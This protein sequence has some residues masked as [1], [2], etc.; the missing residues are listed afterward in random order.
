MPDWSYQTLFRPLL[1]RLPS[2]AARNVT[3]KAMRRVSRL[4]G[5]T[6]L[7][8][9]LGHMEPSPLLE[10]R[11]ANVPVPTPVGLS[12]SVDPDRIAH[13]A[14][15]QFGFGFME[16]GP[17]TLFPVGNGE[18]IRN[19]AKRQ[20]LTYPNEYENEGLV[21]LK[22]RLG[23]PGH[24]LPRFFRASPM[25]DS[26]GEE[27]VDQLRTLLLALRTEKTAGFHIDA[28][29][30]DCGDVANLRALERVG[31]MIRRLRA[32][33]GFRHPVSLRVP[34]D[35]PPN[36]LYLLLSQADL[37]VWSGY[38]VGEALRTPDG[39]EI[40]K[41]GK[42]YAQPLVR[43]LKAHALAHQSIVAGAGVHEPQDAL[44][45]I[46]EGA[47]H[48]LLGSGLVYAGPGLPKRIN[49]ALIYEKIK[50][51]PAPATP[52]FWRHWGWMRLLGIGMIVGGILAWAI[53]ASSVVLP[54]DE[55]F[56]EMTRDELIRLNGH[57]LHFMSHDRITLAGTMISIGILY[58]RLARYGL[59]DGQHWART[60]LLISGIV[61]FPSFFLYLGYGFFDPLHAAAAVVLFPMFLL[62]M[63]RNPDRPFRRPVN[64]R[65]N[66][67]WRRAMWGQLCFVVLGA[68]LSLGGLVIATI[69]V[70]NVFVPQDLAFMGTTREE[71]RTAN[72]NLIPLIAH[73]RA[74][75]GGALFSDAVMLLAVSLWGIQQGERWL[76]WTLLAGGA[77][78]FVAGLSVHYGIAY[79]DFVHLLPAYF[80]VL[81]YILGLIL[82]YPYMMGNPWPTERTRA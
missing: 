17:V 21:R 53:A 79:T 2:R 13:R 45:M 37:S 58:D 64:L 69:G 57:L 1:F 31:A 42:A 18:P 66:P 55:R 73:D 24:D 74:G 75:F 26:S 77:P 8:K 40:G 54:Y 11:V 4:P 47:D 68:S 9:T 35:Y 46:A 61:G 7:I 39:A 70:T 59:R 32:E 60:S 33:D 44:D 82:L 81:L 50:T 19:D 63:R 34:L 43:R 10:S 67:T 29:D 28:L 23:E 71:L 15:A 48:V 3:L 51:E 14:L 22:E 27:A 52:S 12:G 38:V 6:L 65:N 25:P 72:P 62:A 41:S 5:G 49:E 20:L 30:P 36:D 16:I 80:A 78:A 76:W 56:L